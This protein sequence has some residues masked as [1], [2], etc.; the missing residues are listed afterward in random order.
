MVSKTAAALKRAAAKVGPKPSKASKGGQ[1]RK[2]EVLSEKHEAGESDED[3]RT[4]VATRGGMLL[5]SF[6]MT[7]MY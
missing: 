4:K 1:K 6:L 3:Y 7:T 5:V 2:A